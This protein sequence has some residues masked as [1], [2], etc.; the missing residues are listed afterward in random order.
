MMEY[1]FLIDSCVLVLE[2]KKENFRKKRKKFLT[3]P[4]FCRWLCLV[5]NSFSVVR[6]LELGVFG[7]KYMTD[8]RDEFPKDWFENAKLSEYI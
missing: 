7:G 8:C 6:M 1:T 4:I 3:N 2:R 5:I